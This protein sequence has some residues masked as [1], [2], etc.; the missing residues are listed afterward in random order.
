MQE[1]IA[2]ITMENARQLLIEESFNRPVLIDFWADWCAPCKTLMPLLEK[3]ATEY[4]GQF[5]LAKVNADD[6]QQIAMQFGIRS[7]P[8]L[9]LMKDGQPVD[10]INGAV[11]ETELRSFLEK[12]LPKPWDALLAQGQQ[13][14]AEGKFSEA[15]AI[16]KQAHEE[17]RQRPDITVTLALANIEL[18]RLDEAEALLKTVKM[19]HQDSHY[20]QVL[21]HLEL[22]RTATK[23][24]EISALEAKLQ[25][26]PEDLETAYL[27]AIQYNQ[28]SQHRDAM[29]LLISIL[30]KDRDFNDG[31]A[32]RS[33]LDMFKSLGNKD[34]LVAEFQQKL[35]SILY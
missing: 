32:K 16:L 30:Q 29:S 24:P 2:I 33:L 13:A 28:N 8:T 7:L 4:A 5:L 35:F 23:S 19:A 20:E 21:A 11:P 27:L 14:I 3:L 22:K 31:S 34:P 15:L 6:E 17:S 25:A 12:Y 10:G 1:H 18:N 26:N 9:V